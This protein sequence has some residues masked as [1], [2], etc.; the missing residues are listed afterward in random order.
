MVTWTHGR[1]IVKFGVGIPHLNRRAFD[2]NTNAL[3]TYTFGPTLAAGRRHRPHTGAPEL[4][5]TNLPSGYSQNSGDMHFIYHQQEMGAFLQDQC[6]D[7]RPVLHHARP[8]LRLAELPR[9]EAARLLA[10][11]LLRLGPRSRTRRP[12][13]AAAAAST[14]T[15]SAPAPLLDLVRYQDS[16]APPRRQALAQSRHA[17][18]H[19]LRPHHQLH[20]PR[21]G[22][23]LARVELAP[24]SASRTR[25]STASPSS[26]NWA[27]RPPAW[28][29][30]TPR[31]A[32]TSSAPSTSTRPRRSPATPCGP[33]PPTAAFARCS[34]KASSRAA[35]LDI[36]YR[37]RLNKYFT[38]FG[39]YTWSHYESNT[40]GIGWFPQNQ[41]APNDEWSNASFDRRQRL[42][43][44]AMF[45]PEERTQP[46]GR[47]LRQLPAAPGRILTGTDPYGDEPLQH[48]PR[49][50]RAQHR[51]LP[52]P[53][54]TSTC[55]GATTSPSPQQGRRR[56]APGLLRRRIQHP[57]P[58][59]CRQHRHRGD[60]AGLRRGHRPSTRRDASSSACA[61]S[62]KWVSKMHSLDAVIPGEI[63]CRQT[64]SRDLRLL[65]AQTPSAQTWVPHPCAGYCARVEEHDLQ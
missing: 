59:E 17:A 10:A 7:Q 31:A 35:A 46:L 55:A 56:A 60:L 40:D 44:Y 54:S 62:S 41:Y 33:I 32:S 27:R 38:G 43:M 26:A 22:A 61:S 39:R 36:S 1:H 6:E 14:T 63:P 51:E 21:L 13:C 64:V 65:L 9:R 20:R 15:A 4:R 37:G 28:S 5:Q 12:W 52:R 25:S 19:R 48:A 45:N 18:G 3:G 49:W 24:N 16:A 30:S 50:R 2:D 42:G 23:R 57:Q 8:S 29:A 58:P 11:R 34:P 53:M 47:H